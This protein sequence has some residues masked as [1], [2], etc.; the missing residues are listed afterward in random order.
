MAWLALLTLCLTIPF[1]AGSGFISP[2]YQESTGSSQYSSVEVWELGSKQ[3]VAF[4]TD[5]EVYWIELWQQDLKQAQATLASTRVYERKLEYLQS[6]IVR[7]A[8]LS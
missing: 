2:S 3:L 6:F 5:F 8:Q 4:Q 7:Q 1:A